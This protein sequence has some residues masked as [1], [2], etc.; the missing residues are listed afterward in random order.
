MDRFMTYPTKVLASLM[1]EDYRKVMVNRR[2][3]EEQFS[4]QNI[5]DCLKKV[6]V[7]DLR[8]TVK[9]DDGVVIRCYFIG[10][11]MSYA[12]A[13]QKIKDSY[14]AHNEFDFKHV[15]SFERSMLND[16]GPCDL[17]VT[18]GMISGGFSLEVYKKW[19]PSEM[20]LI[21]LH[22]YCVAGIIGHKLMSSKAT[23]IQVDKE[24]QVDVG[25]KIHQLSFSP[26][27]N[28]IGIMD[29]V[30]FLTPKNVILG[31]GEK[32]KMAKL[33]GK[34]EYELGIK[35]YDPANNDVV[36]ITSPHYVKIDAKKAFVE[37]CINPNAKSFDSKVG[38]TS[39]LR[40]KG[41][42]SSPAVKETYDKTVAEG[43]LV[44]DK[45]KR[46]KVVH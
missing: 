30:K 28:S 12:M 31:H 40:S 24:T 22:R 3:E 16:R 11:A 35:C 41:T 37:N 46:P 8:Q 45:T 23:E 20:N 42:S 10:A 21:T 15:C 6:I 32:S 27:T 25:C 9:V 13:S 5:A 7:V 36:H 4:S 43:I 19:A 38:G 14:A 1:L 26:H 44:I 18:P 17:F 2:G 29:L 33:K 39:D 34:I